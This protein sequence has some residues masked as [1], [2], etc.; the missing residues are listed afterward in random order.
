MTSFL[1]RYVSLSF[2][3]LF[4]SPGISTWSICIG[5]CHACTA[6][7]CDLRDPGWGDAGFRHCDFFAVAPIGPSGVV[8]GFLLFPTDGLLGTW[9]TSC[10]V[11]ALFTAAYYDASFHRFLLGGWFLLFCLFV[12]FVCFCGC[13]CFLFC[14]CLWVLFG[15]LLFINGTTSYGFGTTSTG[16]LLQYRLHL[17]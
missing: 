11:T 17:Q 14:C 15:L 8:F 6:S 9:H 2:H 10:L 1:T 13:V 3:P 5:A 16:S 7:Q 4:H 12:G